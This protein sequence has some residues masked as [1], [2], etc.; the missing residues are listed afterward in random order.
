MLAATV[1]LAG[2]VRG[3]RGCARRDQYCAPGQRRA[4][5]RRGSGGPADYDRAAAL[6]GGRTQSRRGCGQPRYQRQ[7]SKLVERFDRVERAQS[8]A[9]KSDA[10]LPKETI[11]ETTAR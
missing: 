6:R 5:A 9:S 2:R 7:Y 11:K 3:E 1:L 4:R 10:A 8:V